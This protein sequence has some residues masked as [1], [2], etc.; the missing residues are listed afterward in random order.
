MVSFFK[1]MVVSYIRQEKVIILD[2]KISQIEYASI[3]W[4]GP[5]IIVA[6]MEQLWLHIL[7]SRWV[8]PSLRP[9]SVA[10][11]TFSARR[12]LPPSV[13]PPSI[14]DSI[15]VP[16]YLLS[17]YL[18]NQINMLPDRKIKRNFLAY[19]VYIIYLLL[20][21]VRTFVTII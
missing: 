12:N 10:F 17:G 21:W 3:L 4:S 1:K 20:K 8:C 11:L 18:L 2:E 5:D 9:I 6:E 13:L 7:K 19:W 16:W 15:H 14:T